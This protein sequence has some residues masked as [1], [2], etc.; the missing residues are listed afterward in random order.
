MRRGWAA[1]A[2]SVLPVARNRDCNRNSNS[3]NNNNNN[4]SIEEEEE[5][6]EEGGSITIFSNNRA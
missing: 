4:N 1:A 3:N 6:K 2:S 5:E